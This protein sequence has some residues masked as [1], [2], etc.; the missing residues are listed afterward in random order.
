MAKK[1]KS[2]PKKTVKPVKVEEKKIE[3]IVEVSETPVEAE[4]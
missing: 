2:T 1:E 3:E 4:V